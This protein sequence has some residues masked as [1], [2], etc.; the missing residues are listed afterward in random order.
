MLISYNMKFYI[1]FYNKTYINFPKIFNIVTYFGNK[2]SNSA[3]TRDNIQIKKTDK[4]RD[5]AI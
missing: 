5:F 4:I 2:N 3:K 1:I